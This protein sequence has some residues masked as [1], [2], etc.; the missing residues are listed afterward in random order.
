MLYNI[1]TRRWRIGNTS[2]TTSP[3]GDVCVASGNLFNYHPPLERL[4][5]SPEML[6]MNRGDGYREVQEERYI[7]NHSLSY[8]ACMFPSIIGYGLIELYLPWT[9]AKDVRS[10]NIYK[11]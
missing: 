10:T 8:H 5:K 1:G 3:V 4:Q 11:E 7:Y 6:A 9:M 2:K